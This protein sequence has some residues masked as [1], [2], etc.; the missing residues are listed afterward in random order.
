MKLLIFVYL[1]TITS[2]SLPTKKKPIIIAHRGAS[3]YLPEHTLESYSYAHAL[4]ADFIEPDVVLTK[5]DIPICIHDIHLEGTTNVEALY[6]ERKRQDGKWYAVDF[7]LKEIKNLS[8]HEREYKGKKVFPKRFPTNTSSF[9][10]P[11]LSEFIE[12]IQGLN[13]TTKKTTGIYPEIK[14]PEFHQKEGKDITKVVIQLIRDYGYEKNPNQIF[15]QSFHPNTLKRLKNEFE[16]KIPLVQLIG[17]NSWGDSSTD[18]EQMRTK[19]G[20]KKIKAYAQG[21][22][23]WIRHL[24]KNSNLLN[25]F[26]K[27]ELLIHPYTF[28]PETADHKTKQIIIKTDGIF[29]DAPDI[30]ID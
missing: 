3:A 1:F 2:C 19:T 30:V 22:G 4:G 16:T 17:D 12:L 20:I 6:P 18:F 23:V 13:Q 14:A 26:K 15:L 25:Y 28:R 29:T 10:V 7:T 27:N 24:K 8:V 21:V 5:D 9:K 11:T